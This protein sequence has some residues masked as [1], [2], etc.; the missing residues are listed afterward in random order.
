M[1]AL[2]PL[3][4]TDLVGLLVRF[5]TR[6]ERWMAS[7]EEQKDETQCVSTIQEDDCGVGYTLVALWDDSPSPNPPFPMILTNPGSS[8]TK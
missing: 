8:T 5:Q 1:I 6:P 3:R 2:A 7:N 4:G